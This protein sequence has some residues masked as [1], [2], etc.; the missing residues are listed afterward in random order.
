MRILASSSRLTL[1][2]E[3]YRVL[4]SAIIDRRIPAGTKLLV[5]TLAEQLDLSPTPIKGALAALEREGLVTAVPHRGHFVTQISARDIEEIYA[6]R[7]VVDGLAAR[8]AAQA[9]D[10]RIVRRLKSLI[11]SQRG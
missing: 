9:A 8:L 7:E 4:R 3:A 6:L 2:A 11:A 10:D 1:Q 5:R